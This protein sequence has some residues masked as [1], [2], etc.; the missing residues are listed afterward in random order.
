MSEMWLIWSLE[1]AAWW[2]PDS[3]GY[4]FK[5]SQAGR[6][7]FQEACDIVRSANRGIGDSPPHEAMILDE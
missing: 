7:T 3:V 5:K 1:H 6:Y 4:C 2:K